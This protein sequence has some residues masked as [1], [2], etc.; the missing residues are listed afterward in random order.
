MCNTQ[1]HLAIHLELIFAEWLEISGCGCSGEEELWLD[2]EQKIVE[3]KGQYIFSTTNL[4]TYN[5]TET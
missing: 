3:E 4:R 1:T 2:H 5:T